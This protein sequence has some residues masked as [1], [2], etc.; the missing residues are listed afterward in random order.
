MTGE[1]AMHRSGTPA[2]APPESIHFSICESSLGR[3]LVAQSERVIGAVRIGHDGDALRRD[4]QA[5]FPDGSLVEGSADMSAVATR[6]IRFIESTG[7]TLD[8]SL[9][10]RG[11]EFQQKVWRALQDIPA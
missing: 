2:D 5:R 7:C 10:L 6:V 9:D 11:T 4:L 3:V 8:V 1:T